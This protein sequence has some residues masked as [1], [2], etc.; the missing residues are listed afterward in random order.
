MIN[1]TKKKKMVMN[2]IIM[3]MMMKMMMMMRMMMKMMIKTTAKYLNKM[4][5]IKSINKLTI[6][7]QSQTNPLKY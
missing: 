5:K 6:K 4:T 1:R 7:I 2:K 3:I